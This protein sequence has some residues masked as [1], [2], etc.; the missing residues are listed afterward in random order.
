MVDK[1]LGVLD[2]ERGL[3]HQGSYDV[4]QFLGNTIGD[5]FPTGHNGSKVGAHLGWLM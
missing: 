4:G 3:A 2:L 5:C 1:L